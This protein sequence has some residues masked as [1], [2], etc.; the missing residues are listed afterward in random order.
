MIC[1]EEFSKDTF[2]F[3]FHYTFMFGMLIFMSL[4]VRVTDYE[5]KVVN[6]GAFLGLLLSLSL[7]FMAS[8]FI[9]ICMFVRF[10]VS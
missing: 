4:L 9:A 7:F 8:C 6:I 10:D 1:P 3:F 5:G 2:F